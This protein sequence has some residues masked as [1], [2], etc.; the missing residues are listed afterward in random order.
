MLDLDPIIG[1]LKDHNIARMGFDFET[2]SKITG[3]RFAVMNGAIANMHRALIQITGHRPSLI[4]PET[5][6]YAPIAARS[7]TTKPP[8]IVDI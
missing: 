3:L 8:S 7:V 6:A 5:V 1:D 4:V 2:A